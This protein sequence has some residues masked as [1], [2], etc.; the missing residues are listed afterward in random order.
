MI[1]ICES[2][3]FFGARRDPPTDRKSTLSFPPDAQRVAAFLSPALG[4]KHK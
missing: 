2:A 3:R 1:R 4:G